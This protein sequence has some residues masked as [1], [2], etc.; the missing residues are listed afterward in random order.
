M[1]VRLI[2]QASIAF[3]TIRFGTGWTNMV[4]AAMGS[5]RCKLTVLGE[6]YRRPVE[7]KRIKPRPPRGAVDLRPICG[8]VGASNWPEVTG[9]QQYAALTGD[10]LRVGICST[11]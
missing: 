11:V 5:K 4:N 2:L 8:W 10:G 6:H 7:R 1:V 3:P 9:A